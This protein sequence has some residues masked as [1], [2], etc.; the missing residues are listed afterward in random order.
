L[1]AL[2]PTGAIG[3]AGTVTTVAALDL[4][5]PRYDR[6]RVHGHRLTREGA[7]AQLARLSLAERRALP[8]MEPGRAPV[9]VAGAAILVAIL[10]AYG[11]DAIE[12]S[13]RD[14]L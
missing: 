12:V 8:A 5:L 14:I 3:V 2:S 6:D 10:D 13:E 11:L 4:E 1:P 9:I 7:R